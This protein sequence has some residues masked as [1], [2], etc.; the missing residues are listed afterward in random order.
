MAG[1]NGLGRHGRI[2]T[3]PKT[4]EGKAVCSQN[5]RKHGLTRFEPDREDARRL[6]A[7]IV[8]HFAVDKALRPMAALLAEEELR[9]LHVQKIVAESF[10]TGEGHAFS[11]RMA[12]RYLLEANAR[13]RSALNALLDAVRGGRA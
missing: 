9:A 5:A 6:T 8:D 11:A 13:R 3:G 1:K 7:A 2:S 12:A 10:A 4:A